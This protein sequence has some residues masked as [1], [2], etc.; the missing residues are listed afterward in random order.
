MNKII[1]IRIT[2]IFNARQNLTYY[3]V[4]RHRANSDIYYSESKRVDLSSKEYSF[5]QSRRG[6]L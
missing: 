1:G 2:I 5:S 3:L 6:M 4:N